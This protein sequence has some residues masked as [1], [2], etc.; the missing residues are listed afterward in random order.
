MATLKGASHR[1]P[2]VGERKAHGRRKATNSTLYNG[3]QWRT[4]SRKHKALNPL[5]VM[6]EAQGRVSPVEVTDHIVPI[7]QGGQ[8][9]AWDNLQSLCHR[10]HNIKSGTEAHE[11]AQER[12]NKG[13][14]GNPSL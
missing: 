4:L 13:K 10:C 1:R 5:C 3:A 7:N 14:G 9:Y 6:C 2:W 12:S 11:R 8:P